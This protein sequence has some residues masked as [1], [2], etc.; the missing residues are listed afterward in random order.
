MSYS[1]QPQAT[2]QIVQPTPPPK[3]DNRN[4]I[5][6]LLTGL[7]LITWGY[8]IWEKNN[9]RS[10]VAQLKNINNNIDSARNAIQTEFNYASAKLDSLTGANVQMQ[11]ALAQRNADI[12]KQRNEINSI[13][14]KKNATAEELSKAKMM[15]ADLNGKIEGLYAEIEKLKGENK[16]LADSNQQL[17]TQKNQLT[18]EKGELQNNLSKTQDEKAK[19][20]DVASTLH[21]SNIAIDGIHAKGSGKEVETDKANRVSALR[22]MF[23]IDENRIAASGKKDLYIAIYNPEGNLIDNAGTF[24]SRDEGDKAYTNKITI[25]YEQGK[26]NAVNFD[27]SKGQGNYQTGNYKIEIYNNGYKIGEAIKTLKKGGL[28]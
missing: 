9:Q 27:F 24:K 28:F 18:T 20:E 11:G 5:Y 8:I 6:A 4:F 2:T 21:A 12:Q 10:E 16:Q 3:K 15:I 14:K 19:V 17:A 23:S 22:I 1:Q 13:L 7:L 26:R 25:D